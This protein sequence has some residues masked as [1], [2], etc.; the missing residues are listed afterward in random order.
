MKKYGIK[1]SSLPTTKPSLASTLLQKAF[2]PMEIDASTYTF[3][4]TNK[5]LKMAEKLAAIVKNQTVHRVAKGQRRPSK[6][7]GV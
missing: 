6:T 5:V 2:V 1:P 3:A 4:R 7:Y